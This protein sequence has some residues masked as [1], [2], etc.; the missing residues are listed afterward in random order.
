MFNIRTQAAC[1]G[2]RSDLVSLS[3]FCAFNSMYASCIIPISTHSRMVHATYLVVGLSV[4]LSC[5]VGVGCLPRPNRSMGASCGLS[6]EDV[7]IAIVC[8]ASQSSQTITP[9]R[10]TIGDDS[11]AKRPPDLLKITSTPQQVKTEGSIPP[12]DRPFS[13][14]AAVWG[15]G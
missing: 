1:A 11:M 9:P 10:T 7:D 4:C 12:A 5:F 3:A 2:P 8:L 13:S 14:A 15:I 6:S